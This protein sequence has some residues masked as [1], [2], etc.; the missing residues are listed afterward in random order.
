L[1]GR[2]FERQDLYVIVVD[3]QVAAMTFEV[4]FAQVVVEESVVL[5]PGKFQFRG[6][7][8]EGFLE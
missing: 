1:R 7:E 3:A 5:E 8:V 2:L 4:R 6:I